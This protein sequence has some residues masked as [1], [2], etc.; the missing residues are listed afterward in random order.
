MGL[1]ETA[2]TT[3]DRGTRRL[4]D[5]L[6]SPSIGCENSRL[7]LFTPGGR[8]FHAFSNSTVTGYVQIV[9]SASACGSD[10]NARKGLDEVAKAKGATQSLSGIGREARSISFATSHTHMEIVFW[11]VGQFNGIVIIQGPRNDSWITAGLAERLARRA[12][13]SASS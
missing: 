4:V 8:P 5:A 2:S 7:A 11:Q 1:Q 12:A 6:R 9:S 10:A 3:P 13:N